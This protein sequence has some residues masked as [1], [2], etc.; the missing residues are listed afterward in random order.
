MLIHASYHEG[1]TLG[2]PSLWDSDWVQA[3]VA[4]EEEE[5]E[6]ESGQY[7]SCR[8]HVLPPASAPTSSPEGRRWP[9]RPQ[10]LGG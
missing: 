9:A 4:V 6:E 5:E 8:D 10:M 2:L 1:E 7:S 3:E